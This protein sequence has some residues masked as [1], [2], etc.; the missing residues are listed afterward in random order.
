MKR[1]LLVIIINENNFGVWIKNVLLKFYPIMENVI[2][3]AQANVVHVVTV[4]CDPRFEERM[5]NCSR[6][7][8]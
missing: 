5:V 8:T 7:V 4:E 6:C 2:D 3:L 1:I